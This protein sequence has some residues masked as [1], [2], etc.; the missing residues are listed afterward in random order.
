MTSASPFA[1]VWVPA[2]DELLIM[3][4][5]LVNWVGS[6]TVTVTCCGFDAQLFTSVTLTV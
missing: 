6:L 1:A 3:L 5:E 2:Q 4:V